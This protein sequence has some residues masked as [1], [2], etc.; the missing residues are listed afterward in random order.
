MKIK[1]HSIVMN[2]IYDLL[3][4]YFESEDDIDENFVKLTNYI[5]NQNILENPDNFHEIM[6]IIN[7]ISKNHNRQHNLIQKK[8]KILN[9]YKY[10]IKQTFSNFQIFG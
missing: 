1:E 2:K 6:I 7:K 10:Q 3:I 9:N 5:K 8:E 4:E